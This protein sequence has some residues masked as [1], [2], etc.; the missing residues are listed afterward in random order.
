MGR[1]VPK[2]DEA[3]IAA[4]IRDGFGRGTGSGY[5]PWLNIRD[6]SSTGTSTRIFSPKLDRA[7]TLFSNIERDAFLLA[8]FQADF[9]DYWEQ[10][11]L[12]RRETSEAAKRIGIA[13]PRYPGTQLLSVMTW[14]GV[15]TR[16]GLDG[17]TQEL[18]DC[19][20]S[21]SLDNPRTL[22]KLALH[23]ELAAQR[24]MTYFLLTEQSIPRVRVHNVEWIRIALPR[25]GEHMSVRRSLD[26]WA[27][28]LLRALQ[29]D[30]GT[31]EDKL[32]L[33]Q[34]C[35]EFD[36]RNQ[37]APGFSLRCLKLLMWHHMVR[38]EMSAPRPG[39]HL[40]G[41][42]SLS[43]TAALGLVKLASRLVGP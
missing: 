6:F 27:P 37:L 19:K 9:S 11:P 38:M 4:R 7:V 32:T 3:K 28:R 16:S 24:G 15:F 20:G 18:L 29:S 17:T 26:M 10:Y 25:S 8:E 36:A 5:K 34:Y 21:S 43:E 13:H 39:L 2:W 30:E 42:L 33:A 35:N 22:E 23:R 12:D 14:D 31:G 41:S 40:V 1:R